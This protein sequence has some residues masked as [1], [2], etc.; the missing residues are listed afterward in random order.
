M[1]IVIVKFDD[2][3]NALRQW[4]F[5][6]PVICAGFVWSLN[7]WS[8]WL[9]SRREDKKILNNIL[10][11]LLLARRLLRKLNHNDIQAIL[12]TL[13]VSIFGPQVGQIPKEDISYITSVLISS[14]VESTFDRDLAKVKEDFLSSIKELSKSYPLTAFD[15]HSNAGVHL[16]TAF[17][18]IEKMMTKINVD[19]KENANQDESRGFIEHLKPLFIDESVLDLDEDISRLAWKIGPLTYYRTKKILKRNFKDIDTEQLERVAIRF[20]QSIN[21]FVQQMEIARKNIEKIDRNER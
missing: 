7:G 1:V 9:R 10:H 18:A 2:M 21:E 19:L 17:D 12:E 20:R 11:N 4:V 16:N 6:V 13:L 15:L 3:I 14:M 8:Q 5:L